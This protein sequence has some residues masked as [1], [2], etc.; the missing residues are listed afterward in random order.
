VWF[1]LKPN[2]FR[3]GTMII[4]TYLKTKKD[5]CKVMFELPT[6]VSAKSAAVVGEFNN[7]DVA[8]MPM[9]RQRDGAFSIALNLATNREYRFR[10]LLDN[11]RWENDT[12]ADKQVA[13]N[14]GSEDS[15]IVL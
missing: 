15:V 12:H 9:K 5:Q 7:W 2:E 10:Y 6:T 4:K 1:E 13:N 8:A 14:F 11:E 3:G